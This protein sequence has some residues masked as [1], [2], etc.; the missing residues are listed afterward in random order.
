MKYNKETKLFCFRNR[1]IVTVFPP[2]DDSLLPDYSRYTVINAAG[3][4]FKLTKESIESD[5]LF[6][7]ASNIDS[8]LYE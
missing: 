1:S 2:K 3:E 8:L 5:Q 4:K 7:L 6:R